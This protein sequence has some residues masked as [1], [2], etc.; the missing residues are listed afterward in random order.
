MDWTKFADKELIDMGRAVPG[1]AVPALTRS[2]AIDACAGFRER[3][4]CLLG[5]D[6]YIWN[7]VKFRSV[8][9]W[10]VDRQPD[11]PWQAFRD[12]SITAAIR[13]IECE[14]ELADEDQ[15]FFV[16]VCSTEVE[17]AKYMYRG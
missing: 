9:G 14:R 11:E 8:Q 10:G 13:E 6:V 16:F 7:G 2:S 4:V 12:R 5:G 1:S 17:T 3:D 15:P